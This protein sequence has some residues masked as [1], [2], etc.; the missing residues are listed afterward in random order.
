MI[1]TTITKEL[2]DRENFESQAEAVLIDTVSQAKCE[3]VL[4]YD[5]EEGYL[6]EIAHLSVPPAFRQKGIA[7]ALIEAAKT[8]AQKEWEEELSC[9]A[10][11]EYDKPLTAEQLAAFYKK[12]G[13]SV[14]D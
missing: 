3:L 7:K 1:T 13:L 5:E 2:A 11:P 10:I 6:A 8:F 4:W 9:R 12:M 14:R